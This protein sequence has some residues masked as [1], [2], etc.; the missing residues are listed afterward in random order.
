MGWRLMRSMSLR[1]WDESCFDIIAWFLRS[2]G[3]SLRRLVMAASK[4]FALLNNLFIT[5]VRRLLHT[6][7]MSEYFRIKVRSKVRSVEPLE[8]L[9]RKF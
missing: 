9:F 1:T 6:R 8:F 7:R 4:V 5:L 3:C 2:S